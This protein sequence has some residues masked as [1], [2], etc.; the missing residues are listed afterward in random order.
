MPPTCNP[1][2]VKRGLQIVSI[3]EAQ[4]NLK[5]AMKYP[6]V[7]LVN[8]LT[9]PLL[10]F[11]FCLPFVMLLII[12]IIWLQLLLNEE[13]PSAEEIKQKS[14]DEPDS[15]SKFEDEATEE[16]NQNET[17]SIETQEETQSSGSLGKL[18]PKP[19]Y[20]SSK[21]TSQKQS[22]LAAISASWCQSQKIRPSH[23]EKNDVCNI[24]MLLCTM[25]SSLTWNFV[26]QLLQISNVLRIQ[27]L[28]SSLIVYMAQLLVLLGEKVV[29]I[30]GS[31][32]LESRGLLAS[33]LGRR[34]KC[35]EAPRATSGLCL[36]STPDKLIQG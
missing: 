16:E 30:L 12:I 5:Q 22:L 25:L 9:F 34:Y 1:C 2:C 18:R 33:V 31:L 23:V 19:A 15:D 8:D 21:P 32:R 11:W 4:R 28:P 35:D 10:F 29:K 3:L 20:L 27:L 26:C 7:P 24:L 14:S 36:F 13:M 17:S 6:L